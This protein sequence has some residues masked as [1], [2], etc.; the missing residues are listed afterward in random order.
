M[1]NVGASVGLN[2][3]VCVG[4][5]VPATPT[6][7]LAYSPSPRQ[8]FLDVDDSGGATHFSSLVHQ[9]LGVDFWSRCLALVASRGP[10]SQPSDAN[11]L[12]LI[13]PR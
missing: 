12:A 9:V 13:E 3:G 1:M 6:N 8:L 11:R 7:T 10:P 2:V 5:A 4:A